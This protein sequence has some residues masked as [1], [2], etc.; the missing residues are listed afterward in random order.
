MNVRTDFRAREIALRD[1]DDDQARTFVSKIRAIP[2]KK[3]KRPTTGIR[4]KN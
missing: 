1:D 4:R 3:P 2:N